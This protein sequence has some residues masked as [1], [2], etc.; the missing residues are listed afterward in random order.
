MMG[1]RI[2]GI[3]RLLEVAPVPIHVQADE[4]PWVA[5]TTGV[6]PDDLATHHGGDVV[7]V[8]EVPIT[9][10]HTP[11]HT[12]GQ[13]VLPGRRPADRRRHPLPRRLRP[14]GPARR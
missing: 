7:T 10:V 8:G 11:G 5:R 6:G 1:W 13:P 3:T 2:E 4:A 9:L 14:H 12:P